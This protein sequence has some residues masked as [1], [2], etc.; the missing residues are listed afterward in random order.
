VPG[1]SD[2][3]SH[4]NEQ[5][6]EPVR[7]FRSRALWAAWLE[8][9]HRK[10]GG[11]WLRLGKKD[12]GLKSVSY[13]EALEVALCYG[14]IDGQKKGES[15]KAWLQRFLPRSAGSIWSKINREKALGLIEGGRMKAAGLEAIEIAKSNGRWKSAYDSPKGAEVPEDLRA[16]LD[17]NPRAR[18]FFQLLDSANRYAILFRIQTVKKAAT[19]SEKIRKF[20][21]MLERKERIH[22][23]RELDVRRS[24]AASLNAKY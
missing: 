2:R 21:E 14:W 4:S 1:P 22:E 13:G 19:R 5:V 17:A 6:A 3:I 12:S 20:V 9:N 24:K 11:L 15:E 16:A 8:K 10:S 23:P 18:D 7:L